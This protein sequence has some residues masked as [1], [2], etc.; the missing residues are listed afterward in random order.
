MNQQNR[1]GPGTVLNNSTIYRFLHR[2][3]LTHLPGKR[4]VDQR[5]FEA[6]L[7]NDLWQ[8]DVMHGPKIDG[9][10]AILSIQPGEDVPARIEALGP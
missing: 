9:D 1:V 7:L 8:S 4:P 10:I 5:K 2:Q 3:N 6:E